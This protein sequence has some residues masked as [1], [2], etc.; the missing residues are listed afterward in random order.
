[1]MCTLHLLMVSGQLC[2]YYDIYYVMLHRFYVFTVIV[3]DISLSYH[4]WLSILI[5]LT[6]SKYLGENPV[7]QVR[8]MF[9]KKVHVIKMIFVRIDFTC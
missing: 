5:S 1:M 6:S 2:Y 8:N 7:V 3:E 4:Q 9:V